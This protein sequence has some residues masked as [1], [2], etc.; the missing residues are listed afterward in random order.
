[1]L[2]HHANAAGNGILHGMNTYLLSI[3]KYFSRISVAQSIQDLHD[4]GLPGAVFSYDCQN[5]TLI[6]PK[7]DMIIRNRLA[8]CFC[9][10]F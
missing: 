1:M 6:H 5:L 10:I 7:A 9:Y 8:I 2:L 3:Q 4:R